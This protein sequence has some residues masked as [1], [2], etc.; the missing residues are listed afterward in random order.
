MSYITRDDMITE[1]GE[2]EI[3]ERTD[4]SIPPGDAIINAVLDS[5][6]NHACSIVDAHLAG[7]YPLPLSTVP[8]FI[9][10]LALDLARC[11]L[12]DDHQPDHIEKRCEAATE[13][14]SKIGK[15]ELSLG[16]DSA[17]KEPSVSNSATVVHDGH[18]FSRKDNGFI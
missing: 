9:K 13:L 11:R 2:R 6:I 10:H 3:I 16:V 14:L 4:R 12:Y 7:R 18:V 17:G 1:F 15:G 5:A 8:G